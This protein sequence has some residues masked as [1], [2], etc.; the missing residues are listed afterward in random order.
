MRSFNAAHQNGFGAINIDA[1]IVLDGRTHSYRRARHL[2]ALSTFVS[3]GDRLSAMAITAM[4]HWLVPSTAGPWQ[5]ASCPV[6][7]MAEAAKPREA[8]RGLLKRLVSPAVV[9]A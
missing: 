8:Q 3:L 9:A 6:T 4:R 1:H 5:L 7:P 2:T